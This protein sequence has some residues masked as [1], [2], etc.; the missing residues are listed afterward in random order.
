MQRFEVSTIESTHKT[1]KVST[2]LT[3]LI[4]SNNRILYYFIK[5]L[6]IQVASAMFDFY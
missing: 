3:T 5:L 2:L 1:I 6:I 4:F